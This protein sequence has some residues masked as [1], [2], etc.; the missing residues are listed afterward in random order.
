MA[1][2]SKNIPYPLFFHTWSRKIKRKKTKSQ[3][4]KFSPV[5]IYTRVIIESQNSWVLLCFFANLSLLDSSF[6][7]TN[8]HQK[9]REKTS[10]NSSKSDANFLPA[11]CLKLPAFA[12]FGKWIFMPQTNSFFFQI[13]MVITSIYICSRGVKGFAKSSHLTTQIS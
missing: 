11:A 12:S 9:P 3:V 1:K 13:F 6:Q 7:N 8:F 2:L 5:H 4:V 10:R